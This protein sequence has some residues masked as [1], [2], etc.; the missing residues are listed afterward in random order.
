METDVVLHEERI[1]LTKPPLQQ[2]AGTKKP[3]LRRASQNDSKGYCQILGISLVTS[4]SDKTPRNSRL[5]IIK[6]AVVRTSNG[7][8]F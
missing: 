7:K 3:K 8:N 1:T 2:G 6:T 4:I 5:F